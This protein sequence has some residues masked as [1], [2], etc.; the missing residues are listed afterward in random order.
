[1][2]L[3]EVVGRLCIVAEKFWSLRAT[4]FQTVVSKTLFPAPLH[5]PQMPV[6]G[7]S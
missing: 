2:A 3:T 7:V 6:L 1:M 5:N 4:V